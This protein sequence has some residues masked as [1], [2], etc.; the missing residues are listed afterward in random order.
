MYKVLENFGDDF[1]TVLATFFLPDAEVI[2]LTYGV[3]FG[4]IF[5]FVTL[6]VLAFAAD[7]FALTSRLAPE[8]LCLLVFSQHPW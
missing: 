2:L 8:N 5:G 4:F 3:E 6:V 1:F 7:G